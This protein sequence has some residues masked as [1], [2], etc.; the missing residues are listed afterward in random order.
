MKVVINAYLLLHTMLC[1]E[2]LNGNTKRK[3]EV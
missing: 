1:M 2:M 3:S